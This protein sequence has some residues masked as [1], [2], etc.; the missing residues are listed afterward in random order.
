MLNYNMIN[1]GCMDRDI[2]TLLIIEHHYYTVDC[3]IK[4][5]KIK[6]IQSN[7]FMLKSVLFIRAQA[8]KGRRP[9]CFP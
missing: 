4:F 1:W 7:C 2:V 9:Y 3:E 6:I 5:T 8:L